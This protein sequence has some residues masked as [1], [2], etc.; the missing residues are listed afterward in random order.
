MI[1]II[2]KFDELDNL[3]RKELKEHT[4][5]GLGQR[6]ALERARELIQKALTP[7]VKY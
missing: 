2:S 7:L 1:E 6:D 4:G 3:I 5:M